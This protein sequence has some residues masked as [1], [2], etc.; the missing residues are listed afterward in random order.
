MQLLNHT[1]ELEAV[2]T[3]LATVGNSP[4]A[5]VEGTG[6]EDVDIAYR[7]LV[8]LTRRV[9]LRAYNWNSDRD[10]PLA[11]D[12]DGYISIPQGALVVDPQD[13]TVNAVVR[14][15]AANG[16]LG[17]WDKANLTF[18]FDATVNCKIIWGFPFQ[19]LPEVA[20]DYIV[21]SAGR[22]FQKR[23]VGSQ[24]LDRYSAEDV[25]GAWA[26]LQGTEL[27]DRNYNLFRDNPGMARINSRSY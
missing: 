11:P 23:Y 21:L 5:A 18:V 20:R 19:D 1:T 15:N 13:P 24:V 16:K 12:T 22:T 14:R 27:R 17:L 25:A 7:M 8:E 26:L 10:Y 3:I 9:N 6:I 2:N 4:V